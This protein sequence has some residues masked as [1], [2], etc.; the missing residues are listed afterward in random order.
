M[1]LNADPR[2]QVTCDFQPDGKDRHANDD[3]VNG[4]VGFEDFVA[5][6]LVT[7]DGHDAINHHNGEASREGEDQKVTRCA[8]KPKVPGALC[9]QV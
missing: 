4:L 7:C 3:R 2:F 5:D 9:N 1:P 6:E 8:I